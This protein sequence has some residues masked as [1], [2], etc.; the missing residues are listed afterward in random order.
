[1]E[2]MELIVEKVKGIV[3]E[4]M[5]REATG[6]DYWHV[7]RVYY[8]ALLL[9][10][11]EEKDKEVNPWV[12]QLAALLH[13]IGDYKITGSHQTQTEVPKQILKQFAVDQRLIDQVVQ[14][15]GEISFHQQTELL[16]SIES[17]IVQDADRLDA[18]GA[19]G[20]A[21]AF[22]YGGAK[23]REIWNPDEPPKLNMSKEEYIQNKGNSINHFYEKLLLLKDKMNTQAGKE[24]AVKRHQFMERF[25]EQ[26]FAEWNGKR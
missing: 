26:F 22:A 1:M 2:S 3:K 25:L 8:N 13:D 15:I 24:I 11:E 10:E 6:H 14:I 4:Q 18:I 17:Q 16:S 19:I 9:L 23:N 20:I 5:L 7:M 21:R 12:V